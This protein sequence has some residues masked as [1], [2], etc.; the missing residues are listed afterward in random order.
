M[1]GVV[2]VRL[3]ELVDGV[4]VEEDTDEVSVDRV[5]G[6][7]DDSSSGVECRRL[8]LGEASRDVGS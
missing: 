5:A 2:F 1:T 7:V 3:E 6:N 8:D 4:V